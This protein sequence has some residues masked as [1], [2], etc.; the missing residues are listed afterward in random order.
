[1]GPSMTGRTHAGTWQLPRPV[2]AAFVMLGVLLLVQIVVEV[3]PAVRRWLG[4]DWFGGEILTDTLYLLPALLVLARAWRP[5][6]G[7]R[8]RAA[9][10][11]L[12]T[13]L[14]SYAVGNGYWYTWI[15]PLDPEPL[16]TFADPLW[17]MLYPGF[18][19]GLMLL[20][21]DRLPRMSPSAWLDGV[22]ASACAAAFA[23]LPFLATVA[24]EPGTTMLALIVNFSY[25]AAD[26]ALAGCVLGAWALTGWRTEPMWLLMVAGM[27]LFTVADAVYL[28]ELFR[29]VDPLPGWIEPLWTLGLAAIAGA[30]WQRPE[31]RRQRQTGRMW[32]SVALPAVF[33]C[34]CMTLLLYG[35]WQYSALPR[36][37]S[38][39]AAVAISAAVLRMLLT[40]RTAEALADA[41]REARTDDLTGLPNRRLFVERLQEE[42]HG[43]PAQQPLTVALLD[44]DRFKEV[45]DS[46]G[47]DVGDRLLQLVAARLSGALGDHVVLAR[48][49]G[50][51][52][53]LVM[54]DQGEE[55]A[56]ETGLAALEA[57]RAPFVL[58]EVA[59]HVDASIGV[60]AFP[61]DGADRPTML[62][63]ADV[64]MYAAKS[65]HTR[66]AFAAGRDDEEARHRLTTL[67]EFRTGLSR[68][69]LLLHYQPQVA[70]TPGREVVGLE[71][72]IRW[73]HP[74]RGLVFPDSFLPIAES[75]G[76]MDLVTAEVLDLA[77][78]QCREW[79]NA[80]LDVSV[81]VNLSP[82]N[83]LDPAFP[84]RV[85]EA[86]DRYGLPPSA[87]DL[88]ITEGVLMKDADTSLRL[89]TALRAQG[90]RIAVDDYGTGYSSLSYLQRLPV[91]DLKLDRAFVG[92]C[93]TD[94]RSAAIV[95]STVGLAHSLGLR[96]IAEGVENEEVFACLAA[97]GCDV[98][99][100]YGIARPAPADRVTEWLRDHTARL[101]TPA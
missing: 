91:D 65:A 24:A 101:R 67:E 11:L 20:L 46:F 15:R 28:V 13:G 78:R 63:R 86:L 68:G 51:E 22:I 87:L 80:G 2:F 25:P 7:R 61:R 37:S 88:E 72:L 66:L 49:G 50:D 69:E 43:R 23:S 99:Q 26:I 3:P 33:A 57:L 100:G 89:L 75:A 47:H 36:V 21:K 44:L 73:N 74:V 29:A 32:A 79:R 18:Y 97:Y 96:I 82:T 48:L 85:A 31:R 8:E 30:A 58:D 64:A 6:T 39:L 38:V 14:V 55:E 41:R 9:W 59:L 52:F 98:A 83:L 92:A 45:N 60:A 40:V 53:G 84:A 10:T 54:P 90:L 93:D 62:R 4:E 81:A 35:S 71:A 77:C 56:R 95:Q 16:V 34:A 5:E 27:T 19:A 12:G 17:L 94:P 76:L 1:M 70:V 42:L